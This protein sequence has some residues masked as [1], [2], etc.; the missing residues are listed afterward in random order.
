MRRL[1]ESVAP[2]NLGKSSLVEASVALAI[3]PHRVETR[4]PSLLLNGT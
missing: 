3:P 2:L 4:Q 1:W